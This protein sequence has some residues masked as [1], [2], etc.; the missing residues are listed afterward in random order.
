MSSTP[1]QQQACR[2][3]LP[4][5]LQEG[6]S[7]CVNGQ[8]RPRSRRRA[9]C[10][11]PDRVRIPGVSQE[12][13]SAEPTVGWTHDFA[14]GRRTS[15]GFSFVQTSSAEAS[16]G[17]GR[18]AV[19]GPRWAAGALVPGPRRAAG[20]LRCHHLALGP[21][22]HSAHHG[23]L[24]LAQTLGQALTARSRPPLSQRLSQSS[25]RLHGAPHTLNLKA[26]GPRIWG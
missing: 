12:H 25:A 1:N 10:P 13:T 15:G 17:R 14:S 9:W 7:S 5:E 19:L 23:L 11:R 24:P 22:P 16:E 8:G 21:L 18:P 3:A 20:A 2:S 26:C 4:A 6:G